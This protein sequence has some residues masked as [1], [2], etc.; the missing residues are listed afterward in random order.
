MPIQ[1]QAEIRLFSQ[2]EYYALN[3]RVL[4]IV[5]DVQNEFGR[6]LAEEL[7]KREIAARC[8]ELGIVPAEREVRIRVTHERFTKDYY[9]DLLLAHGLM[10]EAKARDGTAPAHRTQALNY[11]LL[12]GMQHGTLVNLRTDRVEHEFVS[13]GLTPAARRKFTVDDSK[14][15]DPTP[16]SLLLK[17]HLLD[18]INDWGMFLELSLYRE[19]L[20][21]SLGGA[22][23][24]NRPVEVFSNSRSLGMQTLH[25]LTPEIAFTLSA[26]TDNPTTYGSHLTRFLGHTRLR[27]CQWI[28]LNHHVLELR[29]LSNANAEGRQNDRQA[30]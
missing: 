1:V 17:N 18:L 16:E 19:A 13:T 9:M 3:H 15:V 11:L 14:W 4:R 10:L 21:F 12:A 5:F 2:D 6:L 26:V 28:N 30:K 7:A 29:T 23:L 8:I 27:Y 24:V 20:I 25:L 22:Q